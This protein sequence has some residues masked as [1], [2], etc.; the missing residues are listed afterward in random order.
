M[1]TEFTFGDIVSVAGYENRIFYVDAWREVKETDEW[2][3]SEYVEF[4]LTDAINGEFLDAYE[5]DLRL[6]CRKHFAED[7]LLAYDV[8]DYPEP[9]G[10]AFHFTDD[11]TFGIGYAKKEAVGMEKGPKEAPKKEHAAGAKRKTDE[12]LDE[13]NDNMRLYETF[14][15]AEYK[16]KADAV[17]TKLRREAGE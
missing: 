17:M 12:L 6:V 16:T 8:T 1:K 11:Y 5:M 13:Y 14:G 3:V 10:V 2:G 9:T 7:Y 15:D 4:E